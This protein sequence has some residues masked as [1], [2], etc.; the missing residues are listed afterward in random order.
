MSDIAASYDTTRRSA[1]WINQR[2]GWF[3]FLLVAAVPVPLASNR[4]IFWAAEAIIVGAAALLFLAG[5][6][7]RHDSWRMSPRQLGPAWL[8]IL[9]IAA[10][11]LVQA[12]VPVSPSLAV[13]VWSRSGL[14]GETGYLSVNPAMTL[15]ELVRALTLFF[16]FFLTA[17][18]CRNTKRANRLVAVVFATVA[19]IAA[20][21]IFV[22]ITGSQTILFMKKWAYQD[23]VTGTFV[24]RNAFA[25]YCGIGL[26]CGLAIIIRRL[27]KA[28]DLARRQFKPGISRRTPTFAVV[29]ELIGVSGILALVWLVIFAALIMTASRLGVASALVGVASLL[30]IGMASGR[31]PIG[32]FSV[33]FA[34]AAIAVVFVASTNS[35]L[36]FARLESIDASIEVR[37]AIYRDVLSAIAERPLL[38]YGAGSFPDAFAAFQGEGVPFY[39]RWSYAHNSYLELIFE[40][41]IVVGAAILLLAAYVVG[42]VAVNALRRTDN[43]IAAMAATGSAVVVGLHSFLDFPLQMQ[44]VAITFTALVAAAVAQFEGSKAIRRRSSTGPS[45][46]PGANEA[47]VLEALPEEERKHLEDT[48]PGGGN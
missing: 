15:F 8:I 14:S 19:A 43:S 37:L 31:L 36:L 26:A 48:W 25:S 11:T 39:N 44:A 18:I 40:Y 45:G 12:F 7:F 46:R 35:D 1:H 3:V 17:Q 10:V 6:R 27:Q 20:Y 22:Q 4:P 42:R 28:F 9:L 34:L 24:N 13:P 21:G 33:P 41:G 38:G 2:T 47:S 16:T 32:L 30:V 23:Y 5:N 29:E